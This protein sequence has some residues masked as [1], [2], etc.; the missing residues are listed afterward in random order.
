MQGDGWAVVYI[1]PGEV[2]TADD[3]VEFVAEVAVADVG[4]PEIGGDV[5]GEFDGCE[6][7]SEVVR[8]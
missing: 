4:F 3:V 8:R 6:G 1:A 2:A 7:E 5:D